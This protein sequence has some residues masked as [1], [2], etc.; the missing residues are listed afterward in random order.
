MGKKHFRNSD[1]LCSATTKRYLFVK[2]SHLSCSKDGHVA[3]TLPQEGQITSRKVILLLCFARGQ[4]KDTV[5]YPATSFQ[6]CMDSCKK[7]KV[8]SNEIIIYA[9]KYKQKNGGMK[10]PTHR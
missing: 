4:V 6:H 3:L 2:S 5:S 7:K 10:K 9:K 8:A 1:M